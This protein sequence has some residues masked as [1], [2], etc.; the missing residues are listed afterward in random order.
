MKLLLQKN[1]FRVSPHYGSNICGN[2]LYLMS[3]ISCL[4]AKTNHLG[5]TSLRHQIELNIE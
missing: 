2:T 5:Q 4:G 3:R 1:V